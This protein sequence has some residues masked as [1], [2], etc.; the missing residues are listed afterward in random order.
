MNATKI[1]VT[2]RRVQKELQREKK[3]LWTGEIRED[4]QVEMRLELRDGKDLEK[5]KR[6]DHS[7]IRASTAKQMSSSGWIAVSMNKERHFSMT[8]G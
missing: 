4:F 3:A 8:E 6:T 7:R 1:T 2:A 5:H